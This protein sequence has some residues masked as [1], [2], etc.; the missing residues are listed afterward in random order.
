MLDNYSK[1]ETVTNALEEASPQLLASLAMSG[2][3]VDLLTE[4]VNRYNLQFARTMANQPDREAAFVEEQLLPM[5]T[6]FPRSRN[7][8]PLSVPQRQAVE[9]QLAAWNDQQPASVSP[10]NRPAPI[11]A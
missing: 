1:A 9:R 8:N 3:L 11:S 10:E 7:Q 2:K 5:L 6:E 4:R